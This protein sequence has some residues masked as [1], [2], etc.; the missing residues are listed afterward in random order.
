MK[1]GTKFFSGTSGILLPFRNS[2]YYP[3]Y[4]KESS[5]LNIYSTLNNSVEINSSFYKIPRRQTTEKWAADV[6]ED[7]RFT[8]KLFKGITHVKGLNH[9]PTDIA[10]FFDVI[11][12]VGHKKGCLLVQFPPSF[13]FQKLHELAVLVN[14]LR[15]SDLDVTWNIALEFRDKSW[16]T[17]EVYKLLEINKMGLV[18]HDKALSATPFKNPDVDFAYLRFHGPSGN[19]RESY[20]DD[21]LAEYASYIQEWLDEGKQVFVYFNNT[22]G[23][24]LANLQTLQSKIL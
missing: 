17:E 5:R 21:F 13:K 18:L 12:G 10:R 23:D 22:M 1:M 20:A 19:Y 16:Y 8:F 9:D 11:N 4:H 7:F 24:A 3:E 6:P 15:D 2:A 14:Q